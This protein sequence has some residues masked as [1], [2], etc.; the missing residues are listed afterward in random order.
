M[1]LMKQMGMNMASRT[2]VVAMIGEGTCCMDLI[3][4]SRG[5]SPSSSIRRFTFSM[6]TIASSTTIPI[7]RIRPKRVMR[8]IEYP[9]TDIAAK[10][11]TSETGIAMVGTRVERQSWRKM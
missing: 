5:E 6:T 3:A 11:P 7:A 10:V 4:A 1:P 9:R 2:E 8:L